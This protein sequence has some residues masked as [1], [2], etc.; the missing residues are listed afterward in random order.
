MDHLQQLWNSS[1]AIRVVAMGVAAVLLL[2]FL[3]PQQGG[4][5]HPAITAPPQPSP[6]EKAKAWLPGQTASLPLTPQLPAKLQE[7]VDGELDRIDQTGKV[8]HEGVE[9]GGRLASKVAEAL[10]DVIPDPKSQPSN[11]P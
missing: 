7:T 4:A 11:Q 5:P 6:I 3:L 9:A 8:V 1:T 10:I 2:S